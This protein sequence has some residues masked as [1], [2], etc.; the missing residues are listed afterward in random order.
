MVFFQLHCEMLPI[1]FITKLLKGNFFITLFSSFIFF[2]WHLTYTQCQTHV[3][4]GTLCYLGANEI[5]CLISAAPP[6]PPSTD[7]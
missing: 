3:L 4:S 2:L 6:S 5:T 1:Y 7:C